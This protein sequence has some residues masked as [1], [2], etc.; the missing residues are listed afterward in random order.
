MVDSFALLA[1]VRVDK[2]GGGPLMSPLLVD[3]GGVVGAES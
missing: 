2:E 3:G 1:G